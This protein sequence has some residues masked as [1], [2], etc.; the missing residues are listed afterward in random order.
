MARLNRIKKKI[1]TIEDFEK[2]P[3]WTWDDEMENVQPLS[4]TELAIEEYGDL[5]IKARFKTCGYE[6]DGYLMGGDTFYGFVIFINNKKFM[7]NENLNSLNKSQLYELFW[8]LKCKPFRFFPVEYES[9][10]VL[11]VNRKISGTISFGL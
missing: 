4:E 9:N 8:F 6:F 5:F 1:L 7:F 3:V 11:N 10:V 2:Y